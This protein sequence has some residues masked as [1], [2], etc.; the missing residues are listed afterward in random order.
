MDVVAQMRSLAEWRDFYVMIGTAS[1]AIVGANF[2]VVTLSA[3]VESRSIG[4]RGFISPT[5]VHLA[6]VLLGSAILA[7]P[8]IT[9]L[10][11]AILLGLG[12]LAG[13]GYGVVVLTR[14]WNMKLAIED[15]CWY[16]LLPIVAYLIMLASAVM[17]V[18]HIDSP[19]YALAGSLLLLLVIGMRNAWD[20]ASFMMLRNRA[21]N[22]PP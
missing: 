15:R 21:D 18:V 3:G 5:A 11:L 17:I 10:A 4:I 7:I 14:I 13:A 6:S 9:A 12:G 8:G 16:A 20:M 1:G 19:L 2:V 22:P